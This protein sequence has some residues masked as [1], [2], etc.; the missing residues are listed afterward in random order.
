MEKPLG[1]LLKWLR[2]LGFDTICD[3]DDSNDKRFI[4]SGK[5]KRIRLSR[6]VATR[7][8]KNTNQILFIVSNNPFEQ[9]K[10]VIHTLNIGFGDI[11][12][13]SRCNR[14][15]TLLKPV[16]KDSIRGM[17]PDYVWVTHTNFRFCRCCQKIYWPGNHTKEGKEIIKRLFIFNLNGKF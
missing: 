4:D 3:S 11:R 5:E 6:S 9:L 16:D 2:I 10:Q 8:R 15:N 14:C 12:P 13:F 7:D 17:I 1:K